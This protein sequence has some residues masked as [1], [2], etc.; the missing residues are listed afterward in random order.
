MSKITTCFISDTHGLHGEVGHIPE[1]DLLIHCGDCTNDIGQFWLRN[2]LTWFSECSKAQKVFIAGNHDGAF[3]RWPKQARELVKM[4][5]P[6]IVYLEGDSFDFKGFSI[7]G[8]PY[9]PTFYNW[10]FNR[11]RGAAIRPYWDAIPE[12]TDILVTHGPPKGILDYNARDNFHCGCEELMEAVKRVKPKVHA[13]GHIHSGYGSLQ[14]DGTTFINA[15]LLS[16]RY[17]MANKPIVFQL[18]K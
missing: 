18:E 17:K 11:D 5:D 16:E 10:Y 15:S 14:A 7:F 1:C 4:I 3:E 6:S 2:F 9:T 8:S 13:F 12:G